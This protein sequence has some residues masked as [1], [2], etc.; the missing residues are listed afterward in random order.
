MLKRFILIALLSTLLF[1]NNN[2]V[3]IL[4]ESRAPYVEVAGTTIKGLVATPLIKAL[5]KSNIK[6]NIV[7]KPSKRH[8][9][10]IEANKNNIIF[11]VD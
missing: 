11:I 7:S 5:D 2:D 8:L 4:Y 1:A 9:F 10:E 6:Y 3:E